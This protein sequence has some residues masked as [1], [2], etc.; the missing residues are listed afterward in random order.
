MFV[1]VFLGLALAVTAMSALLLMTFLSVAFAG[2]DRSTA[3]KSM[4][5]TDSSACSCANCQS[6]SAD[7]KKHAR[8]VAV[9]TKNELTDQNLQHSS[10]GPL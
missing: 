5:S 8:D 9:T 3:G 7:Q 6:E 10:G 2:P 4:T 1:I